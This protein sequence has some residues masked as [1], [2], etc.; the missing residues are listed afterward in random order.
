MNESKESNEPNE[1]QAQAKAQSR[2]TNAESETETEAQPVITDGETRAGDAEGGAEA[3]GDTEAEDLGDHAANVQRQIREG[4]G[5][6]L[7]TERLDE[8]GSI[9]TVAE[10]TKLT[11]N[12]A[13]IL[14][15][16]GHNKSPNQVA[17][18]M[19]IAWETVR[20]VRHQVLT[21]KFERLIDDIPKIENTLG[22][23]EPLMMPQR[24][25]NQE[26]RRGQNR[27]GDSESDA[28]Q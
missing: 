12:Q 5:G 6:E 18:E 13:T 17:D 28:D 15:G 7:L 16:L 11:E 19:G 24:E 14:W 26:G 25:P 23:L 3:E 22:L 4:H 27:E 1:P 8:F 2:E 9:E 10:E 20:N 21:D